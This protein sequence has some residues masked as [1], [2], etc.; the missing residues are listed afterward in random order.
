MTKCVV[1]D[2]MNSSQ[3]I[4]GNQAEQE[5]LKNFVAHATVVYDEAFDEQ[6]ALFLISCVEQKILHG[7]GLV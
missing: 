5:L 4:L 2:V 7:C 1:I 6:M 3:G